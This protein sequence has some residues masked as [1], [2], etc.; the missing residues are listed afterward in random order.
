MVTKMDILAG[1]AME[2]DGDHADAGAPSVVPHTQNSKA[3][4]V[5]TSK[6]KKKYTCGYNG[7]T[8]WRVR[9]GR[10]VSHSGFP[11]TQEGGLRKFDGML[12]ITA[13]MDAAAAAG[14]R[15]DVPVTTCTSTSTPRSSMDVQQEQ[16]PG[17]QAIEEELS[18][19]N[20]MVA[21]QSATTTATNK[22]ET[23][24]E[25]CGGSMNM[26]IFHSS[27][28]KVGKESSWEMYYAQ[29][30][31]YKET[32]C[33]NNN[34]SNTINDI[35]TLYELGSWVQNQR[36]TLYELGSWVQ[37]QRQKKRD[38]SLGD[39][40]RMK[41][42]KLGLDWRDD[43]DVGGS[44]VDGLLSPNESG[45]GLESTHNTTVADSSGGQYQVPSTARSNQLVLSEKEDKSTTTTSSH[46][47]VKDNAGRSNN[48]TT[49]KAPVQN[50]V[51]REQAAS[52]DTTSSQTTNVSNLEHKKPPTPTR[53]SSESPV[54][55]DT[56]AI[57]IPI[58]M[59]SS[60]SSNLRSSPRLKEAKLATRVAKTLSDSISSPSSRINTASD[61]LEGSRYL[62]SNTSV[63][64][65]DDTAL[66]KPVRVTSERL[67]G[68]ISVSSSAKRKAAEVNGD[69]DDSSSLPEMKYARY[70]SSMSKERNSEKIMPPVHAAK[71]ND[72]PFSSITQQHPNDCLFGRGPSI[73]NHPGNIRFRIMAKQKATR[74]QKAENNNERRSIAMEIVSAWRK[75]G[76]RFLKF[77]EGSTTWQ[78]EGDDAAC[79]KCFAAFRDYATPV[80]SSKQPSSSSAVTKKVSS[81]T[82]V[83]SRPPRWNE[84]EVRLMFLKNYLSVRRIHIS[85]I[86]SLLVLRC[87]SF[88]LLQDEHLRA[89][90]EILHPEVA[91]APETKLAEFIHDINWNSV[92]DKLYDIS[93]GGSR[94]DQAAARK[95]AECMRRY[96]KLTGATKGGAQKAGAFIGPWTE[97]E[98]RIVIEFV[99][100][101]GARKWSQIANELPGKSEIKCVLLLDSTLSLT[102]TCFD[103]SFVNDQGELASNVENGGTII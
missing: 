47:V 42:E 2:T 66:Y 63:P 84:N 36:P 60:E 12:H 96:T 101:F 34:G 19:H 29:L 67:K 103:T 39:I 55:D 43:G 17:Q 98:D 22:Q 10:C 88:I 81:P 14:L 46:D 13:E 51:K 83:S 5:A 6:T 90:V 21:A 102:Y 35:P 89:I 30:V 4:S 62:E 92:S 77:D 16:P 71:N 3:S 49:S 1:A 8:K 99:Q 54:V 78:D 25:Y 61:N 38:K 24:G 100:K 95:P 91:S 37:N 9:N 31:Q 27:M 28:Y 48:V 72:H 65:G 50:G 74:Y 41:L 57:T 94:S 68:V 23:A 7:C 15:S 59:T 45:E 87:L 82:N 93:R 56:R 86:L 76:W 18:S 58:I 11:R 33:G 97:E 70:Y 40:R 80:A 53:K 26:N 52:D 32:H 69:G 20:S 64:S 85:F 44:G 73:S 79:A 75:Q